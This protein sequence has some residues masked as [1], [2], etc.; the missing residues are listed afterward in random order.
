MATA[1]DWYKLQE[2][3][4]FAAADFDQ[5][6]TSRAKKNALGALQRVLRDMDKVPGGSHVAD[7]RREYERRLEK[8]AGFKL[9]GSRGKPPAKKAAPKR[10]TKRRR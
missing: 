9:P 2:R 6:G 3:F 4:A 1:T 5:A 7:Y 8:L 10:S